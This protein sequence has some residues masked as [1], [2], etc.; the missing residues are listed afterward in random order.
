MQDANCIVVV[1]EGPTPNGGWQKGVISWTVSLIICSN[2]REKHLTWHPSLQRLCD[3]SCISK[4]SRCAILSR[5]M[6]LDEL[7]VLSRRNNIMTILTNLNLARGMAGMLRCGSS[8]LLFA[9]KPSKTSLTASRV[10][11]LF[12][13]Q[14]AK[15]AHVVNRIRLLVPSS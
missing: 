15:P 8:N 7:I 6:S 10:T 13:L 5:R 1:Y 3:I 9:A 11:Q 12:T 2:T 4:C 14:R